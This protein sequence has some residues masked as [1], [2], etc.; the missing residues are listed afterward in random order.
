MMMMTMLL[1]LLLFVT[2]NYVHIDWFQTNSIV[3]SMSCITQDERRTRNRPPIIAYL[4]IRRTLFRRFLFRSLQRQTKV[5]IKSQDL[6]QIC[7]NSCKNTQ[8]YMVCSKRTASTVTDWI[9]ACHLAVVE[10]EAL[11]SQRGQHVG[12]T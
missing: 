8:I 5:A 6:P 1:L 4:S 12:P 3:T 11:L 10:Q 9:V 2:M 7:S